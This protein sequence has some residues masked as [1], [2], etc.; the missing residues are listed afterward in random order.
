[1]QTYDLFIDG[2]WT[3]GT[4]S[5]ELE[6]INP[7]TEETIGRV[8]Q[9]STKDVILAVEAARRAFD[10]GPW[11]RSTPKE[12]SRVLE[13]FHEKLTARKAELVDLTIREAGSTFLM[14]DMLQ[15]QTPLDHLGWWAERAATFPYIEPLPP[16]AGMGLGQGAIHKE[17][18]GVVAAI[19]PFNFPIF[20]NLW[21]L[22]PALAMG[23]TVVL[24]PS[25]HT[26]LEAF[27]LA[28]VVAELDLPPG[29]VNI[30][31][32]DIEA[33]E[34]LTTHPD[35]DLV[36]FT[37]SDVVGRKV[38]GQASDSLKKVLLELG[39]KSA[40]IVFSGA[41][42]DKV[43]PGAAMGFTIH[44]GQGCALMTR[45]LVQR[46]IHDEFVERVKT[47]LGFV[48]VGDPSDA[49]VMMGPLIRESQRERV[50]SYVAKGKAE[51]AEIAFGGG[52][53]AGL[54]KG[55]FVEPTLFTNVD[56]SM[57]IAQDEIFGP[58]G[59]VIPFDTEEDAIRIAND[60]RYGLGGGVWHPDPIRAYE[61]AK[62][63]RT[64]MVVVNG[65]GGAM[66]SQ[67]STFGGYKHSG[68]GRE[69]SDHGLQEYC[70]LKTVVWGAGNA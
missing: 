16:M 45:L 20:L 32:G 50:E 30:V 41:N 48:S 34:K 28:E 44:C 68:V 63:L 54:D 38:M 35:V 66:I 19:T 53:P 47:F 36:S 42:L 7:A 10:E 25:P 17:P 37:G 4:G 26:P 33:G 69:M 8:P 52:R 43:V 12:R 67:Y 55:F 70:E 57:T 15:V 18:V 3:P 11:G 31:T 9:A 58:V 60:S 46:S 5:E 24:K 21:K 1:M 6:V 61:V 49:S 29:V 64:G 59:V 39:G 27:I 51:G 22:G 13:K 2:A 56:N 14:A 23:N 65:G 40:N 62:R